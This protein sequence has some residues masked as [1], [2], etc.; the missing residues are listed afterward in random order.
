MKYI[1]IFLILTCFGCSNGND[2]SIK[3]GKVGKIN[4]ETIVRQLDSLFSNDSIVKRIGEGDYMFSGEDNYLIFDNTQIHLL[5]LT[6]KQQHDSNEK[7]E[8]IEILSE[9]YKTTKGVN[10]NST[11]G[12]IKRNHTISSI[13]NTIN[14][15][16]IFVDEIDA[17]FII[18]KKN[19]PLELRI[20]TE[21]KIESINIPLN[22]K[23]KRFMIGWN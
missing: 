11:F 16:V 9:K 13:Q 23:I 8:T 14:N 10:T 22:S 7:I 2:Y 6:P 3:K 15:I 18:D 4:S 12:D 19:L 20:G 17:Y 1:T 5:T 21:K